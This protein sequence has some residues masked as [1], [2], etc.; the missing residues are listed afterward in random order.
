MVEEERVDLLERL[1]V[2]VSVWS[3]SYNMVSVGVTRK[4]G[5]ANRKPPAS[6][7]LESLLIG[8]AVFVDVFLERFPAA[9]L[10]PFITAELADRMMEDTVDDF[11]V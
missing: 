4:D 11:M 1:A 8:V 6:V 9:T 3:S 7:F 5:A 10:V 2:C